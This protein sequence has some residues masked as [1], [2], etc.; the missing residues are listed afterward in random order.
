MF[1]IFRKKQQEYKM[2]AAA[3][4]KVIPMA[5]AHDPV[6]RKSTRLNSSHP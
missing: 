4:G 3:D 2:M 5:E 1:G 6:D